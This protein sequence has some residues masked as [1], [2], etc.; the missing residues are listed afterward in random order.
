LKNCPNLEVLD[1]SGLLNLL[2]LANEIGCD[3]AK[4]VSDLLE[5]I[6]IKEIDLRSTL[7]FFFNFQE[8]T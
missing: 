2:I 6:P 3:G 5:L 7:D 1:F 8:I 4:S